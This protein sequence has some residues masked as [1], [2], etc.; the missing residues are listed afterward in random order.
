MRL[1]LD[2]TALKWS[3]RSSKIIR[4]A[5]GLIPLDWCPN[6]KRKRSQ[7][8]PPQHSE[9]ATWRY[10]EKVAVC[11]L[12]RED[13]SKIKHSGAWSW[14]SSPLN[15]ENIDFY[16][17]GL[18]VCD[19]LLGQQAN[20]SLFVEI[21]VHFLKGMKQPNLCKFKLFYHDL[22][23]GP[24]FPWVKECDTWWMTESFL[25]RTVQGSMFLSTSW[26]PPRCL[27]R[28]TSD[29]LMLWKGMYQR[30]K[31]GQVSSVCKIRTGKLN[32]TVSRSLAENAKTT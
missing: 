30:Q 20:T 15:C 4:W 6:N 32:S 12:G 11:K 2:I 22:S 13:S 8:S 16:C 27:Y 23:R 5:G 3:L 7:S 28:E 21:Y 14:T 17:S 19:M 1:C 24:I 10:R 31:E 25:G 18:P 26:N 29:R 9:K